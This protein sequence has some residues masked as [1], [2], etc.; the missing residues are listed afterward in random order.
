MSEL[1]H[2]KELLNTGSGTEGSLLIEKTIHA[3]LISEVDKNLIPRDL[4]AVYVGPSAISGSSYDFNLEVPNTGDVRLTAEGAAYFMDNADY[5]SVNVRPLKY[6]V[7]LRITRELMEDSK[8]PILQNQLMTFG[9]RM[10]EN[11]NS[12]VIAAL[13]GAANT[14][15]AG[16]AVTPLD[17]TSMQTYLEEND[18]E[19]TDL[20]VGNEVL[21]DIRNIDTFVEAN[22]A[23]DNEIL[24]TGFKGVLYGARVHRVSTNAGM[25]TT[26]AYGLDRRQAYAI[27][28]KRTYTTEGFEVPTHDMSAAVLSQRVA[29]ALLRSSAVCKLTSS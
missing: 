9:R 1:Q 27:V 5:T 25:T 20:L 17:I 16:A 12:L 23:G 4:A 29:V 10:A 22:K 2:V 3:T 11:E 15:A 6:G 28:E 8:F 21:R 18:Y 24:Q 7:V 19:M 14:Q 13:D 26:S